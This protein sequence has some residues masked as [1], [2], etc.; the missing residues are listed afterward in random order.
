[1]DLEQYRQFIR[2]I[3]SERAQRTPIQQ[4]AQEYE[5]QTIFD[6]EQDRYQLLYVGWR[7]DK[8]DFGCILYVNIKNGKI[9][10]QHDGT[11]AG[12]A[13]QLVEMGVPKQDIILAFH[14][15]YVRQFTDFGTGE[16]SLSEMVKPKA[17]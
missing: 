12:I 3:L 4:N 8:R 7:G 16:V 17:R 6:S 1:M 9:W 14:E 11:E 5:V 2:Q 13:N 15:P 10:I